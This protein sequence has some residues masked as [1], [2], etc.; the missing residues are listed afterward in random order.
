MA[1][2]GK[3]KTFGL[4]SCRDLLS[5]LEWE[6]EGLR[7]TQTSDVSSLIYQAFNGAVTA[8]HLA[9]WVWGDMTG[10]QRVAICNEWGLV[11]R[12]IGEFR[13]GL[14]KNNWAVALCREIATAS[15]HVQV[16][17]SPDA[18]VQ[19]TV[20]AVSSL[21]TATGRAVRT[22]S[23]SEVTVTGWKLK[24]FDGSDWHEMLDVLEEARN[25][26]TTFIYDREF[27]IDF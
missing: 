20:S 2:P 6:I 9:D 17:Q 7:S 22:E 8:W 14:R 13:H 24:V 1:L 19:T 5:K 18:D 12:S 3:D 10:E 21:V 15:K 11:A 26:W 16:S 25:F 27:A 23:G 4:E